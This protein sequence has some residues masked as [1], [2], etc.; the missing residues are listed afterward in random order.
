MPYPT[1][2]NVDLDDPET[3]FLPALGLI[4][5]LQSSPTMLPDKWAR[6]ISKHLFELGYRLDPSKAIK[7]LQPPVRGQITT[8]NPA[9]TYVD[10]DT[11]DPPMLNI[12][13]SKQMT[14]HE[15][16]AMIQ[17]FDEGGYLPKPEAPENSASVVVD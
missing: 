17:D 3:H 14:P 6:A 15:I 13:S 11:P 5:G 16:A 2:Q 10:I 9:G 12:P 1:P 8:Y 4:P 7:K